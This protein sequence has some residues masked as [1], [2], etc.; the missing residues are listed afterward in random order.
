MSWQYQTEYGHKCESNYLGARDIR[1]WLDKYTSRLYG[2]LPTWSCKTRLSFFCTYRFAHSGDTST[3]LLSDVS[4]RG[5]NIILRKS[6]PQ[7][8]GRCSSAYDLVY[9]M[10]RFNDWGTYSKHAWP[11]YM[12]RDFSSLF[13]VSVSH[14]YVKYISALRS[15][16]WK[17]W[18]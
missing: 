13:S 5:A 1:Q 6:Y 11:S 16:Q 4:L 8:E 2:Y 12:T 18:T 14:P 10:G 17:E 9:R 15:C 3:R 7:I